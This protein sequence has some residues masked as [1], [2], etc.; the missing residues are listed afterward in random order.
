MESIAASLAAEVDGDAYRGL[1]QNPDPSSSAYTAM[2]EALRRARD[3]NRRADTWVKYV[4]AVHRSPADP[5]V[6]LI[7][8]DPEEYP[9]E[10]ARFGE[11]YHTSRNLADLVDRTVVDSEISTDEFGRW[12][13]ANAPIRD[14]A[15]RVVGAI[16]TEFSD[17]RVRQ[18]MR[19][20]LVSGLLAMALAIL[21]SLGAAWL[22][23]THVSR[24]LAALHGAA[25]RI[26]RGDLHASAGIPPG[27]EFGEVS[28][29]LDEMTRGL[30]ERET[31]KSA[32]A[33]YVSQQV[34]DSVLASGSAPE[35]KGG[36]RRITV[37]FC[38][39]RGF[40]TMSEN[41]RPEDVVQILNEYFERMVD[42]VFRNQGTLDKFLGDGLM[43]IF[44]APA[45]DPY[46]EE[47]ALRTAVEMQRELGLLC[48]KWRLEG[49]APV[50]I[51]IGIH[52]G[53][54]VVGNVGSS[55]RMEYTAIGDTVNIASRLESATKELGAEILISETTYA[56]LRGGLEA[57]P[58]GAIHV[59]GRTEPVQVFAVGHHAVG[60]PATGMAALEKATANAPAPEPADTSVYPE[61]KAP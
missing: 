38:D 9:A 59:K 47:H 50:R 37:L 61:T 51:G 5:R 18:Q 52:S 30:R 58:R 22:L 29:A 21:S 14:R 57:A 32:F 25:G 48:E 26:G 8:I 6:I 60:H 20:L 35:I 3:A 42:V 56:A 39:I 46:Q 16:V 7:G 12:L 53:A 23:S 1:I 15:G 28:R 2:R 31:V 24:P 19:P 55:R 43:V 54:S 45:D 34:M 10:R 36:R 11:V 13:A 27:D 4:F 17:T 49:R 41:M 44:G 33:R 40:S